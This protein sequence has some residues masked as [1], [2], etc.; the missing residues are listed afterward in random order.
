MGREGTTLE[1][2]KP[3]GW[4]EGVGTGCS[5]GGDDDG[6]RGGSSVL[7]VGFAVVEGGARGAGFE[8]LPGRVDAEEGQHGEGDTD[9]RSVHH[10]QIVIAR[11]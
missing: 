10:T 6:R 7:G 11:E 9:G 3:E 1:G 8:V 2:G 5:G 4:G